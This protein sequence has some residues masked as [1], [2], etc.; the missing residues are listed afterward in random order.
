MTPTGC[1]KLF[2]QATALRTSPPP[3]RTSSYDPHRLSQAVLTTYG[4]QDTS[5]SQ[6]SSSQQDL[7]SPKLS[8]SYEPHP[9]DFD[10]RRP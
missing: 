2:P 6:F 3:S 1:P 8:S 9:Q 10:P 7:G 4:P 5:F